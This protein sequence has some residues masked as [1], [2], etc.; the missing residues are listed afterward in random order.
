MGPRDLKWPSSAT[1]PSLPAEPSHRP[2]PRDFDNSHVTQGHLLSSCLQAGTS[3]RTFWAVGLEES[4]GR[5][6]LK[7][8]ARDWGVLHPHFSGWSICLRGPA[9]DHVVQLGKEGTLLFCEI[10]YRSESGAESNGREGIYSC[11]KFK[12]HCPNCAT[13]EK[14]PLAPG[15]TSGVP[16]Q[17]CTCHRSS[18]SLPHTQEGRRRGRWGGLGFVLLLSWTVIFF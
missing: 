2:C 18:Q 8:L 6:C 16:R 12:C 3:L 11:F 9:W 14:P 15:T 1:S 13:L 4:E 10:G 7:L 5:W 17:A